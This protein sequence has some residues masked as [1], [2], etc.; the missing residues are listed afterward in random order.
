MF[1][2][3]K[4]IYAIIS[5]RG[6]AMKSRIIKRLICALAAAVMMIACAMPAYALHN[7]ASSYIIDVH[8]ENAPEEAAYADI[9]VP[10]LKVQEYTD[11]HETKITNYDKSIADIDKNS[12]IVNYIDDEGFISLSAHTQTVQHI[13]LQI[14]HS[15]RIGGRIIAGRIRLK[16]DNDEHDAGWLKRNYEELKIAFVDKNGKVISVTDKASF[17]TVD[18]QEYPEMTSSGGS[19]LKFG[20]HKYVSDLEAIIVILLALFAFAA[21]IALAIAIIRGIIK[22]TV[23]GIRENKDKGENENGGRNMP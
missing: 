11:Y 23:Q 10:A 15:S 4:W 13:D 20:T 12:E 21:C 18:D 19:E 9:L 16:K 8:L 2:Y 3:C 1:A 7:Y 22:S 6:N 17:H 5:K 14:F